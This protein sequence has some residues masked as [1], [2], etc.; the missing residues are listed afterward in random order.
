MSE[1]LTTTFFID[2]CLGNKLIVETLRTA[3]LKVEIH[4]DH[5]SK[6]ALDTDWIPEVAKRKWIILTKDAKISKN[7]LE[8][9]AVASAKV[10]MF[11]LASQQLSGSQ[12]ADIF[13]TAIPSMYELISRNSAPFIAKV[14]Q[15]G[16]AKMWRDSED[17]LLELEQFL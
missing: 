17:L 12:M 2:R 15:N 13:E 11:I 16:S 3:G 8:R 5:F 10:K 4:D 14:Y 7:Q 9:L 6:D 1:V